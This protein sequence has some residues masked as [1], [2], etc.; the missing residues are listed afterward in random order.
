MQ[1]RDTKK[2]VMLSARIPA[3]FHKKMKILCVQ[4]GISIQDFVFQALKETYGRE[5]KRK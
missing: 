2:N 3:D 5:S 1:T 4:R